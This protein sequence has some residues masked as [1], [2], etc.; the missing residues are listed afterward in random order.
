MLLQEDSCFFNAQRDPHHCLAVCFCLSLG[1]H[2]GW[3]KAAAWLMV[4]A[5]LSQ[6]NPPELSVCTRGWLGSGDGLFNIKSILF[7]CLLLAGELSDAVSVQDREMLSGR[8]EN[9]GP[10]LFA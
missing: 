9:S 4:Q 5:V 7:Q 8:A 3:F 6:V 2:L 1:F 10:L